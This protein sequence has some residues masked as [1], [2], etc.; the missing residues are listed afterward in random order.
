MKAIEWR[1]GAA[2]LLAAVLFA[3]APAPAADAPAG[4]LYAPYA[5]LIGDWDV[6]PESGGAPVARTLFRW[7]PNQSY[8]WFATSLIEGGKETPHFEG[9]LVWN[10]ARKNLDMLLAL[11][12]EN[13]GRSQERGTVALRD[14]G[15]VVRE[16]IATSTGPDGKATTARFRQT[17]TPASAD[18]I[19]T[20]VL[21]ESGQRFVATFPGSDKL[22][23][24]RRKS[25]A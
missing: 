7:G 23:M 15:T 18:R 22:V 19:L 9:I 13:G 4:S 17:F 11:D 14:D 16:I 1:S 24:V 12:L 8:V 21:R 5:F 25:A 6:I 3:A 2:G 20:S 10:G